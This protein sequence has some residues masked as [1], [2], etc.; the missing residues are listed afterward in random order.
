M[1]ISFIGLGIM[2][3]PMSKNLL[4]AGYQLCVYDI[5]AESMNEAVHAGAKPAASA[6]EA[7]ADADIIITMLPN[8]PQVKDVLLGNGGV[9]HA[10]RKGALIIDMSSIA[11]EASRQCEAAAKAAG[12]RLMDAPVSGGEPKA[13]DGTL[14]IMCGGEQDDFDEVYPMLMKMGASAV[15]CGPVGSGN[16]TKLC[17]QIIVGVNIAAM[18]EALTLAAKA[19]VSPE[20]VYKAIRGGAGGFRCTGCQSA[21]GVETGFPAGLPDRSAYQGPQKRYGGCWRNRQPNAVYRASTGH[22]GAAV[23]RGRRTVRSLRRCAV[24]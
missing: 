8:S 23:R 1:K 14:S 11:P 18:G 10:A 22:Y 5:V 6:A 2:G 4:R 24:F 12:L 9:I 21:E 16:V 3:K 15:L 19:G 20:T 13:I 17:N 7:A